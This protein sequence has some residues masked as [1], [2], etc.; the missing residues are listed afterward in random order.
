MRKRLVVLELTLMELVVDDDDGRSWN[1][2][3][4]STRYWITL[5]LELFTS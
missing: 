2:D 5:D 4:V 1:V 3:L